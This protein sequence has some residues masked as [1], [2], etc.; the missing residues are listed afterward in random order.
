MQKE[1]DAERLKH[2]STKAK[3]VRHAGHLCVLPL[4][5]SHLPP[6]GPLGYRAVIKRFKRYKKIWFLD[7]VE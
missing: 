3:M 4:N 7:L 1:K 2:L 5:N 6:L